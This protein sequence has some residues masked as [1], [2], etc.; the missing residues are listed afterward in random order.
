ME[1]S[2]AAFGR[3]TGK[4]WDFNVTIRRFISPREL[5]A[6]I[7]SSLV[8]LKQ[9]AISVVQRQCPERTIPTPLTAAKIASPSPTYSL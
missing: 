8:D 2:F 9:A 7:E 3:L 1:H 5:T 4:F 6:A